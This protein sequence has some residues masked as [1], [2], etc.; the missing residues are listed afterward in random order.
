MKI[1]VNTAPLCWVRGCRGCYLESTPQLS[2]SL[3]CK[4]DTHPVCLSAWN[5]K[6][7]NDDTYKIIYS[8]SSKPINSNH[9]HQWMVSPLSD[10]PVSVFGHV[11]VTDDVVHAGQSLVHVLLQ[12]LQIL[13]LFVDWDDGVLQL[14]QATLERR[15][16]GDLSGREFRHQLVSKTDI[17]LPQWRLHSSEKAFTVRKNK[18]TTLH[19]ICFFNTY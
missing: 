4:Q 10:D 15:Q 2:E 19:L 6:I 7:Q 3:Q 17:N 12:T 16:D 9:R 14:H 1:K 5:R 13:C 11:V 8:F 18:D